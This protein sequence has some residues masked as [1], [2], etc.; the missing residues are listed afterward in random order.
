MIPLDYTLSIREAR[1]PV[2]AFPARTAKTQE[3]RFQGNTC[4]R[5]GKHIPDTRGLVA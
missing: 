3:P 2:F 1:L 5:V 4:A